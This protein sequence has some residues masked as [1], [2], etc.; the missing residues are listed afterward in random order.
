MSRPTQD[1]A[2]AAYLYRYQTF[3]VYGVTFQTLPVRYA[4]DIAVLQ[5]RRCRNI[6]GLGYTRFA[7][8]YF[9]YRY[10]FLLLRVLRCFSSPGLPHN[11][12]HAFSMTGCPIR[13]SPDQVLF[14]DPRR[15][16]QLS[17]SFIASGSLGILR[18]PFVTSSI[19]LEIA[20]PNFHYRLINLLVCF[21]LFISL[22]IS[23]NLSRNPETF[24][25][26]RTYAV[27]TSTKRRK[28]RSAPKR[29][30]SSHTFRYGYLVTT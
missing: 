18:S 27:K 10:F 20:V 6:D 17:T 9:G 4:F 19:F 16:S 28:S 13:I 11:W 26:F 1:T 25:R 15:F 14:A 24:H 3:T 30:C 22:S 5:P 29:R 21:Y 12:C 8:H 23:M 2:T 7:R